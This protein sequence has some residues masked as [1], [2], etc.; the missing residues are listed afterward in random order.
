LKE[1]Q[2]YFQGR[3][4]KNGG[5]V[6]EKMRD[7]RAFTLIELMVVIVIISVLVSI[8][9]AT[10]SMAKATA[11]RRACQAN[12]R[13]LDGAVHTYQASQ[14]KWPSGMSD[15]APDYVKKEPK[16]PINGADYF[17]NTTT[18]EFACPNNGQLVDGIDVTGHQYP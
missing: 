6:E 18:H 16:A 3:T 5:I 9:I 11:Y 13:T 12:L 8:A 15:L 1:A 7:E 14:N 10:S 17:Y 4:L 2:A